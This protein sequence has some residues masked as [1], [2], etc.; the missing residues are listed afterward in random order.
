M[1]V[2]SKDMYTVKRFLLQ[3]KGLVMPF[4]KQGVH[5]KLNIENV[6]VHKALRTLESKEYVSKVGNW[7][8]AWYFV[9]EEG[10]RMLH[11]EVGLPNEGREKERQEIKN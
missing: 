4:S 9:T 10:D 7:Q 3:N 8:H 1:F 5:D 2:G 11:D 6:Y